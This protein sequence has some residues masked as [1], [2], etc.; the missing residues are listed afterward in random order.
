MGSN[1]GLQPPYYMTMQLPGAKNSHFTIASS[2]VP[3]GNRQNLTAIAVANSDNGPDYGKITLL[4]LPR[5]TNI[6]GPSQVASNFESAPVIAQSL[7]LLRQGGSDVVLGNLL[8]LPVGGGLLYVQPVYVRST[9]NSSSYPLLQKVMVS[10]GDQI[11]FDNTFKGALDQIFGGNAGT[12]ASGTT[13]ASTSSGSTSLTSN[14]SLNQ[15]LK[16][17]QQALNDSQTALKNGDFSAYG[18]AQNR[19]KSAISTAI[20]AQSRTSATQSSKV[21]KK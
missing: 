20:A 3:R 18:Q 4:Q 1:Q 6:A 8:T 16:D 21:S 9:N 15:A 5:S 13:S 11:G 17:A 12:N 2:F 14:A 7:S 19:L 10:F